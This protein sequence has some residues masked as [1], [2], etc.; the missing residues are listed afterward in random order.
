MLNDSKNS[1]LSSSDGEAD[2]LL[3]EESDDETELRA[4]SITEED[5]EELEDDFFL[6]K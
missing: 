6:R 2:N 5:V 3:L 4:A 1:E